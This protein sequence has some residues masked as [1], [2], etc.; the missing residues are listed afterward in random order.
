[1]CKVTPSLA[2]RPRCNYDDW[3]HATNHTDPRPDA[4][5][6]H[7]ISADFPYW[8]RRLCA[9]HKGGNN[10]LFHDAA[11]P[12]CRSPSPHPLSADM[13]FGQSCRRPL[14]PAVLRHR[15][16]F[17]HTSFRLRL[18]TYSR[19]RKTLNKPEKLS[20]SA[21]EVMRRNSTAGEAGP[22]ARGNIMA[23]SREHT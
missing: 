4:T 22:R 12:R 15:I 14:S 19:W 16:G 20:S 2:L 6:D 21:R 1:V 23:R 17:N 3:G 9:G 8:L 7:P 10:P 13:S 18:S 11:M 5:S